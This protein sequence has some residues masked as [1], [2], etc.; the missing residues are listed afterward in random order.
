V[1]VAMRQMGEAWGQ[2]DREVMRPLF[3]GPG[4]RP[5]SS[6]NIAEQQQQQQQ[7]QSRSPAG[8]TSGSA[9]SNLLP[10]SDALQACRVLYNAA[11]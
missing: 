10:K 1:L 9:G 7:Q 2:F 5:S 3:G 4:S 8:P 6:D 11:P